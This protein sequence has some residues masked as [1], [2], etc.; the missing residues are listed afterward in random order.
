MLAQPR[1]VHV[2]GLLGKFSDFE[3][4]VEGAS[5]WTILVFSPDWWCVDPEAGPPRRMVCCC[6]LYEEGGSTD[7]AKDAHWKVARVQQ[8]PLDSS[9][10]PL[11]S[12]VTEEVLGALN[13]VPSGVK[14][15]EIVLTFLPITALEPGPDP[16]AEAAHQAHCCQ[17]ALSQL[18]SVPVRILDAAQ[19]TC[20]QSLRDRLLDWLVDQ[21]A[22]LTLRSVDSPSVCRA[23]PDLCSP[24]SPHPA[25]RFPWG[26]SQRSTNGWKLYSLPSDEQWRAVVVEESSGKLP[27]LHAFQ[28]V[29]DA[30]W[31]VERMTAKNA[32][33]ERFD[34]HLHD[35]GELRIS[36]K[37]E[38]PGVPFFDIL[39]FTQRFGV[40]AP[41]LEVTQR[42]PVKRVATNGHGSDQLANRLDA[43]ESRA[44]KTLPV[45]AGLVESALKICAIME[46]LV[47]VEPSELPSQLHRCG[48]CG[49]PR[50]SC[51]RC[52]GCKVM[53]Y[54]SQDHQQMDWKKHKKHCSLLKLCATP[55][56]QNAEAKHTTGESEGLNISEYF[57]RWNSK[58]SPS[59]QSGAGCVDVHTIV[60]DVTGIL[61]FFESHQRQ[62][63]SPLFSNYVRMTLVCTDLK[64]SMENSVYILRMGELS[65]VEGMGSIGDVWRESLKPRTDTEVARI[66]VCRGPYTAV[67][68]SPYVQFTDPPILLALSNTAAEGMSYF[69]GVLRE[70]AKRTQLSTPAGRSSY[71]FVSSYYAAVRTLEVLNHY[72]EEIESPKRLTS[73]CIL[74]NKG[75]SGPSILPD[76]PGP[77]IQIS[78]NSFC[79]AID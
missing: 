7:G 40:G 54:C 68:H 66:R 38:R 49:R 75:G 67:V 1:F 37:R 3:N 74:P 51:G 77:E 39:S 28:D 44:M 27:I 55:E 61:R 34:D 52:G 79:L 76:T 41:A 59:E 56:T 43:R 2:G 10:T 18:A 29:G 58:R 30:V 46:E 35:D 31:I 19:R 11:Y 60:T 6:F 22:G 47:L 33:C 26:C 13:A 23:Y 32:S 73:E 71:L 53:W 5:G 12:Q 69:D 70:A 50:S 45:D 72:L 65:L 25:D 62:A 9:R 14:P 15:L 16:E 48:Y 20:F 36:W 17:I 57:N 78:V 24:S 42:I 8:F 64:D 4:F 21:K 63:G